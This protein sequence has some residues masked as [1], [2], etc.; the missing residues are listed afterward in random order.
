VIV[1]TE[2]ALLVCP[3]E[4]EQQVRELVNQLKSD[5]LSQWL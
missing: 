1:D 3:K 5:G 4:Q 2:D